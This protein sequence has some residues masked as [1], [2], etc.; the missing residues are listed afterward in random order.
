MYRRFQTNVTESCFV[1]EDTIKLEPGSTLSR[2]IT[3]LE[4]RQPTRKSTPE[5]SHTTSRSGSHDGLDDKERERKSLVSGLD[6]SVMSVLN[7]SRQPTW[8]STLRQSH[9]TSRSGSRDGL[10]DKK[11]EETSLVSGL[12]VSV[13]SVLKESRQ[14]TRKS[15]PE[16]SH[17]TSS[18][19]S[20][21]ELD[22]KKSEETSLVSGLQVSVMS[23]GPDTNLL[24]V[25]CCAYKLLGV[26]AS[27][28]SNAFSITKGIAINFLEL[29][30]HSHANLFAITI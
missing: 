3:Q 26:R 18:S 19:G 2:Y 1:H 10:D 16:Q 13:M 5:Q 20:H 23:V 12:D 15:T 11:S 8:K 4:S 22:D 21:D 29:W 25:A 7:E 27:G 28:P 14:P 30:S 6:V 17:T 24:P 9:T